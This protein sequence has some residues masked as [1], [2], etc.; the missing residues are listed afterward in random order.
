MVTELAPG[1][2]T[3]A[4]LYRELV[5]M[6]TEVGKALTHIEVINSRNTDAD[7]LH[8]DHETRIRTLERFR[9][10][11]AGLALAGGTAMGLLGAII[12]RALTH[13]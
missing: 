6:R 5:L 4:D 11:L 13:H 9:F 3:I 2:V 12:E 7:K 10:T 1:A 8:S